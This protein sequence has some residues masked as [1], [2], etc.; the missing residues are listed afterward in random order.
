MPWLHEGYHAE[1]Q[2]SELPPSMQ[3]WAL[4]FP[5]ML[6]GELYGGLEFT[7]KQQESETLLALAQ[8]TELLD[9][10]HSQM[11]AFVGDY[12]EN[13]TSVAVID[14]TFTEQAGGREKS[15]SLAL[16]PNS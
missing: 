6:E 10:L 2:R 13:S 5:L 9:S 7:G 14:E 12:K 3:R 15:E 4:K 1:W 11:A 16:L 8:L